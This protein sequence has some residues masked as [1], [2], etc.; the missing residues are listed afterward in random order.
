VTRDRL[1]WAVLRA[2]GCHRVV[3]VWL[4][5]GRTAA[6]RDQD[7]SLAVAALHGTVAATGAVLTACKAPRVIKPVSCRCSSSW[8]LMP[9]ASSRLRLAATWT[10]WHSLHRGRSVAPA[11]RV[12]RDD[13]GIHMTSVTT[14]R[15]TRPQRCSLLAISPRLRHQTPV[16]PSDTVFHVRHLDQGN[17]TG[18]PGR[19]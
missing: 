2:A 14:I 15:M 1:T 11:L 18:S 3:R 7:I 4:R 17:P 10:G 6:R 5:A 19:M 8:V 9:R 13:E 12:P 16:M